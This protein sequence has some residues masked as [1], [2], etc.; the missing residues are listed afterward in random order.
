[1]TKKS[2]NKPCRDENNPHIPRC[3]SKEFI[4]YE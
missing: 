4:N 3:K 1:M 2:E